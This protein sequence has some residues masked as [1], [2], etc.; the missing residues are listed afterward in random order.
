MW[1]SKI[2]SNFYIYRIFGDNLDLRGKLSVLL[3]IFT[4][5]LVTLAQCTFLVCFFLYQWHYLL[6][7]S[8]LL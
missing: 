5:L 7:Q 6:V 2:F 4:T 8:R 3:P 1:V